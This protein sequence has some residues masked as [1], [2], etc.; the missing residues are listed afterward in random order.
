[1]IPGKSKEIE[2]Q[3]QEIKPMNTDI[4][5]TDFYKSIESLTSLLQISIKR[6]ILRSI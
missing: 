3:I 2:N 1:M 4:A 5:I 6:F